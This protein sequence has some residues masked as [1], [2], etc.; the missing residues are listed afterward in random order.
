MTVCH[1]LSL[2]LIRMSLFK[3]S[4]LRI[5][6]CW[7]LEKIWSVIKFLK[8]PMPTSESLHYCKTLLFSKNMPKCI[9]FYFYQ[10]YF[11]NLSENYSTPSRTVVARIRNARQFFSPSV[12][13]PTTSQ[14]RRGVGERGGT[15]S[16][17]TGGR[18]EGGSAPYLTQINHQIKKNLCL[19]WNSSIYS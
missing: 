14:S 11:K 12:M 5:F 4:S 1:T 9:V 13:S 3:K 2:T 8:I 15:K 18:V 10:K 7:L 17:C 19:I 16:C 6:K